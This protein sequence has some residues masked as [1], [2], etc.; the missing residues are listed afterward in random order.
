MQ[1]NY[2]DYKYT[3]FTLDEAWLIIF[4]LIVTGIVLQESNGD[5]QYGF[6]A[7]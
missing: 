4:Q 6:L 5:T 2:G 1:S 7:S 3:N